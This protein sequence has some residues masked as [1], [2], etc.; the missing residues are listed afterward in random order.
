MKVY[1]E[2]LTDFNGVIKTSF[3]GQ[4]FVALIILNE[5]FYIILIIC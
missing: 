4:G 1:L 5:F 2:E 3:L